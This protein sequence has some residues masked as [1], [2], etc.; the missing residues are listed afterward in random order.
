MW[1]TISQVV[2]KIFKSKTLILGWVTVA[3]GAL[4]YVAG[5]DFIQQYPNFVA[6]LVS[7]IGALNL[8]I[9]TVTFL[10]LDLKSGLNK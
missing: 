5:H 8:V 3:A 2:T 1:D 9:R 7:V 10:P 4:G 6:V